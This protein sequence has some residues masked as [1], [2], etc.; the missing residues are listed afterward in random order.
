MEKRPRD[1]TGRESIMKQGLAQKRARL[2]S[3]PSAVPTGVAK[4]RQ[5]KSF[6]RG[7]C[8]AGFQAGRDAR[9]FLIDMQGLT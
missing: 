9:K 8:V 2:L 7:Q 6:Q 4:K 1:V 3:T 5:G